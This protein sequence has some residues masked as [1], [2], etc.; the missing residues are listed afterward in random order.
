[1]HQLPGGEQIGGVIVET[2][3]YLAWDD[4]AAHNR[5]GQT[6]ATRALFMQGGTIYIHQMR[7]YVGMDIV[8][9][10][11][12]KPSSVLLRA[13]Q[14]T[15]GVDLME[16]N[17]GTA[18]VNALANGPGKLCQALRITKDYNCADILDP[19]SRLKLLL[20]PPTLQRPALMTSN[21]VGVKTDGHLPL[22]FFFAENRYVSHWKPASRKRACGGSANP[23]FDTSRSSYP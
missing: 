14:P 21:R 23:E 22:R 8:T 2:E 1:M 18:D 4:G 10:S 15:D 11:A 20:P 7:A 3:A 6:N 19:S 16:Q 5:R 13:I 17:R 12:D 9:E